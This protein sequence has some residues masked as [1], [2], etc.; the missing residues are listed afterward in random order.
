MLCPL[1]WEPLH[2][3][4]GYMASTW[5]AAGLQETP[6][7]ET[8]ALPRSPSGRQCPLPRRWPLPA[9]CLGTLHQ[10]LCGAPGTLDSLPVTGSVP[11]SFPGRRAGPGG[12]FAGSASVMKAESQEA[13]PRLLL[14]AGKEQSP[15]KSKSPPGV[16][17]MAGKAQSKALLKRGSPASV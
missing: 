10:D 2:L 6:G 1:P 3:G 16:L 9:D 12:P 11:P 17:F 14:P 15:A 13:R 5:R 7:K 4:P 8:D